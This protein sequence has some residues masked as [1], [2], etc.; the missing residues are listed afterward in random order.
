MGYPFPERE[1]LKRRIV[2]VAYRAQE[3]HV[4]SAL[5]ILDIVWT[6]YSKTMGPNDK[7][8]L[9][10]AH[11]CLA[12]YAILERRP[13]WSGLLNDF[14]QPP[15]GLRGHPERDLELG[16]E[17]TTGSLG[18][19]LPIA[20]GT[21]L[22]KKIKKEEGRVFC[23]VGD[24]E[25]E[26]GSCWESLHIASRLNLSNLIVIVDCNG[27][28]PNRIDTHGSLSDKFL[29]F[30][31]FVMRCNGHDTTILE[32]ML[33]PCGGNAPCVLIADTVKGKGILE[34]ESDPQ[35]WHHRPPTREML[36]LEPA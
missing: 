26:E 10:K 22:A 5:S 32:R 18:H 15:K 16:V 19:A 31:W 9:G 11:G 8:V 20:C 14:C 7:F 4:P 30:G 21:A 1:S 24:G 36:E 3:G 25:L 13:G 28:S 12:L 6:L 34:M 27:T 35:A 2:E 23:L 17:A 29:A 33:E